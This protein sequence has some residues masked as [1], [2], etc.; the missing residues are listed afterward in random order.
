MNV[1]ATSLLST[2]IRRFDEAAL[3]SVRSATALSDPNSDG[4]NLVG[5]LINLSTASQ[6]VRAVAATVSVED[7]LQ[8]S[9]LDIVA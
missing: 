9:T 3:S 2:A 8:R 6:T 7:E 5:D 1:T 4:G